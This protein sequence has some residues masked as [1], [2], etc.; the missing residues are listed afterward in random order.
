MIKV[1]AAFEEVLATT[2]NIAL[3][4]AM[5]KEIPYNT[6]LLREYHRIHLRGRVEKHEHL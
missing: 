3:S 5:V 1:V 4:T 6:E 2:H